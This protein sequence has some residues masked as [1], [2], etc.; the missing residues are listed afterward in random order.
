[1]DIMHTVTGSCAGPD[2]GTRTEPITA[3]GE[4]TPTGF[5]FASFGALFGGSGSLTITVSGDRGTGTILI[6]DLAP[7][8]A[9]VELAVEITRGRG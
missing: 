7:G 8:I 1:M 3:T 6:T 2:V 4:R 9:M 5:E